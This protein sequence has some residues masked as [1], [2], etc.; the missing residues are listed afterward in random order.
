MYT[1]KAWKQW[2]FMNEANFG[3]VASQEEKE[4]GPATKA[5]ELGVA[6]KVKPQ[7]AKVQKVRRQT[8]IEWGDPG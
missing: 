2:K 3:K 8:P 5:G 6:R 7:R 1:C 4:K